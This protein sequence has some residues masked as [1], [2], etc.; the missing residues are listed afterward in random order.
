MG[1]SIELPKID[2]CITGDLCAKS[3]LDYDCV[4]VGYLVADSCTATKPAEFLQFPQKHFELDK[5]IKQ[6]RRRYKPSFTL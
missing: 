3:C 2:L 4:Q 1:E 6:Q 5:L